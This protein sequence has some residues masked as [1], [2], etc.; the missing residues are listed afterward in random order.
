[1][2]SPHGRWD[3][4]VYYLG[5]GRRFCM[6]S[7]VE[8]TARRLGAGLVPGLGGFDWSGPEGSWIRVP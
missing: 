2:L 4:D 3:R 1:M 6:K 7:M 5:E 8:H